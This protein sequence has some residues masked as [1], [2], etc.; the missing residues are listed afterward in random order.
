MK[1]KIT[2][3]WDVNY[4]ILSQ[5]LVTP[6]V[7]HVVS[8]GT[9]TPNCITCGAH[10]GVSH[11]M[12]NCPLARAF[13]VYL[14]NTF[15]L[16]ISE[17]EWLFGTAST[18]VLPFIWLTNFVI[19]K[20][21]LCSFH[22]ERLPLLVCFSNDLSQFASLFPVLHKLEEIHF[23]TYYVLQD[24]TVDWHTSSSSEYPMTAS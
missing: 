17:R 15:E 18:Y 10:A 8:P 16:S 14:C 22:G 12:L 20:F 11:I 2:K 5:I 7:L 19:Y 1:C 6:V 3:F 13:H 23:N 21:Y 24:G 9:G 4:K